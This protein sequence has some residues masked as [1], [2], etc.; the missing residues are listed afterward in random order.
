M[1][2]DTTTIE[3]P[4]LHLNRLLKRW[5]RIGSQANLYAM[6]GIG[7]NSISLAPI[8]E[9]TFGYIGAQADYETTKVYTAISGHTLLFSDRTPFAIR[10]RFGLAP[11]VAEYNNLQIWVVGQIDHISDMQEQPRFTPMLR[12]FYRTALWETGVSLNGTYWFQ[13][14]AH[15]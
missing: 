12:F 13:M 9:N 5:N 10:G 8:L 1:E 2:L 7:Y 4:I 3:A 6:A 14:M 15:F 11:Y